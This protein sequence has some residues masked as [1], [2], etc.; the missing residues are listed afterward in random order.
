MN[1][2]EL[3]WNNSLALI[4][5]FT[6][7][8]TECVM[9][10]PYTYPDY[11]VR[12]HCANH[13]YRTLQKFEIFEEL[14]IMNNMAIYSM[15]ESLT[16]DSIHAYTV[17]NEI[18]D[19][20]HNFLQGVSFHGLSSDLIDRFSID[21]IVLYSELPLISELTVLCDEEDTD[22]YLPCCPGGSCISETLSITHNNIARNVANKVVSCMDTTFWIWIANHGG[23]WKL[24]Y[25]D[26]NG[27]D[28]DSL[29]IGNY[30]LYI[31]GSCGNGHFGF[32]VDDTIE[33]M[34]ELW[35]NKFFDKGAI[36]A[37]GAGASVHLFEFPLNITAESI[38]TQTIGEII[39][40][41]GKIYNL[42]GDPAFNISS[43]TASYN[44]SFMQVGIISP[45]LFL[46]RAL[47]LEKFLKDIVLAFIHTM[48]RL[49]YTGM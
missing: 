18:T 40:N 41:S 6:G 25:N 8:R 37:I 17:Y 19:V 24:H 29:N 20:S 12:E 23:V 32:F 4:G 46:I 21:T 28:V 48:K 1:K 39:Y 13:L 42:F 30:C 27:H 36:C 15:P 35:M 3:H 31:D 5:S 49:V 14:S 44:I 16:N 2:D 34:C 7:D 38:N 22:C 43:D 45:Y 11:D 9:R 26:L 47:L 10:S 33:C